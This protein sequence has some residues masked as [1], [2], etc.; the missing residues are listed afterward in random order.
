MEFWTPP[1]SAQ[2]FQSTLSMRR[3]TAGAVRTVPHAFISIHA[4][5]EE[6]DQSPYG[7][8]ELSLGFQSTLSMRRA[9]QIKEI[10][11]P[12][13]GDFNPRSP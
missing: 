8:G 12:G 13:I 7:V 3:A 1:A 2:Q 5:H 4:L 6:S 11:K 9:T 10:D